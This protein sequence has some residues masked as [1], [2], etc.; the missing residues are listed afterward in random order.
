MRTDD[1]VRDAL[2]DLAPVAPADNTALAGMHRAIGRRRRRQQV[3]RIAAAVAFVAL[4]VG[5]TAVVLDAESDPSQISTDPDDTTTPTTTPTTPTTTATVPETTEGG[6]AETDRITFG[7]VSFQLPEGWEIIERRDQGSTDL[8]TGEPGP[9]GET[10]CI[11][12]V[13]DQ[14]TQVGL[15]WDGCSGLLIHQGDF[16]PGH[17]MDAYQQHDPWAW[18]HNTDAAPCPTDP[19][20]S[21]DYIQAPDGMGPIDQG[22][23]A[24][25][26][27]TASYDRWRAVCPQSGFS[28]EPQAWFLPQS[29]VLIFDVF[30]H[31]ETEAFLASFEFDG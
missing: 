11:A 16:L 2:A 26:D 13:D 20:G 27:R 18:Y 15:Q 5:T 4:A 21:E 9:T 3:A 31:D 25:G 6:P 10:M 29:K 30:G 23:R 7:P 19:V 17:E 1:M 14:G 22:F 28:F 12:P 24:V 8:S